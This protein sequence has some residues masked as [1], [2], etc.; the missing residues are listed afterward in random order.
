MN[1]ALSQEEGGTVTVIGPGVRV[2]VGV[3]GVPVTVGVGVAPPIRTMTGLP[4]MA[5]SP[6]GEPYADMNRMSVTFCPANGLRSRFARYVR[7]SY[8]SRNVQKVRM[9]PPTS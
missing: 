3:G 2:G 8:L 6:M 9:R 4:Q 5:R 1:C 7:P